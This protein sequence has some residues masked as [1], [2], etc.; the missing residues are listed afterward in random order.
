MKTRKVQHSKREASRARTI[1]RAVESR[2]TWLILILVIPSIAQETRSSSRLYE[3]GARQQV[4]AQASSATAAGRDRRANATRSESISARNIEKR[5]SHEADF[6]EASN[7]QMVFQWME[8]SSF[9]IG[10]VRP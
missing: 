3:W 10:S 5:E 1:F 4:H 2:V 8:S 7:V 9:P 6:A